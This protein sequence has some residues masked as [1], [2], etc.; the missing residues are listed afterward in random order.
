MT[1]VTTTSGPVVG[2]EKAGVFLFAGV[3]YAAPPVGALRFRAPLPHVGWKEPLECRRFGAAAPQ[4]STGGMT[5]PSPVRWSE[6]CLT[7]NI[8]T[9]SLDDGRRPVLFWIHGG[10]YRT[11]QG[12]IP[13]YN[14][15]AFCR[16]G[17]VVVVSINYRLGAL[18]FTD[19][20]ALDGSYAT[21]GVNGTLDQIAALKWVRDN[22]DRFGG[23]PEKITIAGESAGGF[24]VATL[25]ANPQCQGLFRGAIAQSGAGH[26]TLPPAAGRVVGEHFLRALG[27]DS[28]AAAHAASVDDILT[29]QSTVIRELEARA[30]F[31]N[32]LGLPVSPFYPVHGNA[33]ISQAPIDAIR[34]GAG[35]DIALLTGTNQD[36]TTLWGYGK[37]DEARLQQ[38]ADGLNAAIPLAVHRRLT[39][40]ASAEEL[41]IA[42]TTEHMFRIPAIR[43][44]EARAQ[45][46]ASTWMYLFKWRSQAAGGRFGAT[47]ALEIPFAFNNLGQPGVPAFLGP[48]EPP[49]GLAD[50]MHEAWI[51]FIRS[52]DPGW[53]PYDLAAR[54]TYVFADTSAPSVDPE[55]AIRQAWEGLR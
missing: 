41:L 50:H 9:P 51:R 45:Q 26:H 20:S 33:V 6:D 34:G 53:A 16:N 14:G 17:D 1:R 35:R 31:V 46:G 13:W 12:A 28:I 18:G 24:S 42:L 10:G 29:A 40:Q 39:P 3:P 22:I 43:L 21:S 4:V 27:A 30:G 44:A 54:T 19:L 55:S 25:L 23:D 15:A 11:G 48:G 47:H 49:Q 8:Q 36:E 52:G 37:V 7:L 38:A 5:D 32:G 2:R